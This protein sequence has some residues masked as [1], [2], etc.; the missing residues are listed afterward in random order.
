MRKI[1]R[2]MT[3]CI[4]MICILFS[5][6]CQNVIFRD[7]FQT[8]EVCE[9][10]KGTTEAPEAVTESTTESS[11]DIYVHVC[12]CVR[13]PGLYLF[14]PGQRVDAAIQ[15]AGGFTRKADQKSV[16]L[17]EILVDGSQIEVLS[18]EKAKEEATKEQE[19]DKIN[20][21]TADLTQLVTLN[22]IGAGKAA[23]IISYRET[24]GRFTSIEEIC[25]VDGIGQATYQK[26]K[27]AIV[28]E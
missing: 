26:L 3:V 20:I 8:E 5:T 12:G 18:Y 15:A 28:V 23:A 10:E 6:G 19:S 9:V 4:F 22:G 14:Q 7:L 16:N 11:G 1:F 2:G 13:Q 25:N 21:N 17:A 27:D 24:Q